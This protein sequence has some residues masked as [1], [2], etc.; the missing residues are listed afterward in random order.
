[1][2][3]FD[4]GQGGQALAGEAFGE[5]GQE[6][7][8][9]AAHGELVVAGV[10][11]QFDGFGAEDVGELVGEVAGRGV[12]GELLVDRDVFARERGRVGHGLLRGGR[13][14]DGCEAVDAGGDVGVGGFERG[15]GVGGC[16]VG[17]GPVQPPP[18]VGGQVFVGVVAHRDD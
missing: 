8:D 5:Q 12:Q 9:A 14:E 1:A 15:V 16:G 6:V 17:Y 18:G 3:A 2:V 7:R 4:L 11:E 13:G 10:Q